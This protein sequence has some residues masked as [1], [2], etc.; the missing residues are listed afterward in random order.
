VQRMFE[1]A[2]AAVG[3]T[4]TLHALRHT[5]AYRMAEDPDLPL[6]NVQSVLGHFPANHASARLGCPTRH[7]YGS[8]CVQSPAPGCMNV[9]V[10]PVI[11]FVQHTQG[12]VLA[13]PA[14]RR[15]P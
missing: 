3:G 8:G 14:F 13:R 7:G 2:G 12:Q 6:T 10:H 15:M 1:R 9:A 5:T 4:A 11:Q